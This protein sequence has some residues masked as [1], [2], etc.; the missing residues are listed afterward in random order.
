MS[1]QTGRRHPSI[2]LTRLLGIICSSVFCERVL[3]ISLK[4]INS[5][6]FDTFLNTLDFFVHIITF[7]FSMKISCFQSRNNLNQFHQLKGHFTKLL[8]FAPSNLFQFFHLLFKSNLMQAQGNVSYF[9]P[10]IW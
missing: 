3:F 7:H 6:D 2:V 5:A 8:C 1:L 10:I 9:Y 4:L